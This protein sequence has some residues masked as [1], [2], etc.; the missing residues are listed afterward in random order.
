MECFSASV[1]T[2]A[3]ISLLA[4]D[5]HLQSAPAAQRARQLFALH[6]DR[7]T[8]DPTNHSRELAPLAGH[9]PAVLLGPPWWFFDS[10]LGI[11]HFLDSVVETAGMYNLAKL[12]L[13]DDTR[14][15]CSIP[16]RHDVWRRVTCDWLAGQ[17]VEGL[18]GADQ[19]P[20]R[21]LS[22][23][24]AGEARLSPGVIYAMR[25]F[26]AHCMKFCM[27]WLQALRGLQPLHRHSLNDEKGSCLMKRYAVVGL[28]R[29]SAH[30][31]GCAA[32]HLPG[33][34]S[35]GRISAISTRPAWTT[36]IAC[37]PGASAPGV[38]TYRAAGV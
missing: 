13:N 27:Q 29:V 16:A 4:V 9:Y 20:A 2:R 30:V 19:A 14:A 33:R 15:F 18:I 1:R 5:R 17:V 34:R 11:R 7:F 31:C 38:P 10:V 24:H 32:D 6:A 12:I 25:A 37:E 23:I 35:A 36:T 3:P 26:G 28:D 22:G 21:W 8:L